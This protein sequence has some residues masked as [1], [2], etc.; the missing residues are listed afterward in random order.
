MSCRTA[1]S[2]AISVDAPGHAGH[3][4]GAVRLPAHRLVRHL[5]VG[6][7]LL[8]EAVLALEQRLHLGQKHAGF[9]ALDD[10]VVVGAGDRHDLADAEHGRHFGRRALVLGGVVDGAGGDDGALARHQ[11]RNG[12]HGADRAGVGQGDGGALEI[13]HR[14]TSGAGAGDQVVEGGQELLEVQ[15]PAFLMLGT[16]KDREPLFPGKSIAMPKLIRLRWMRA[17]SPSFSA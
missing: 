9:R 6:E 3:G 4:G 14:E 2:L 8:V 13:L 11:A 5:Q 1:A 10:A 16:T 17:A 12:A 15:A 7:D